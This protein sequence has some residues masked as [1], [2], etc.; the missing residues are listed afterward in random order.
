MRHIASLVLLAALTAAAQQEDPFVDFP[1]GAFVDTGFK[2][3]SKTRVVMDATVQSDTE[4]WFGMWSVDW[5]ICAFAAGNDGNGVFTAYGS[6]GY[7]N[8]P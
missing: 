3:D 5:D 8:T 7:G 2:P 1:K 6:S 4:Y